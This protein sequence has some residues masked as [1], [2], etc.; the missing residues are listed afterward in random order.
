MFS[1]CNK[2]IPANVKNDAFSITVFIIKIGTFLA[3]NFL[4]KAIDPFLHF[5]V[6]QTFP[7]K[8]S[9]FLLLYILVDSTHIQSLNQLNHASIPLKLNRILT[10]E[11]KSI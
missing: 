10:G 7:L 6:S 4:E 5:K 3:I 11:L 8:T 9:T 2:S 1:A